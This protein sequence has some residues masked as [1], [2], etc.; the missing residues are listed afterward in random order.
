MSQ[1]RTIM[2]NKLRKSPLMY[3]KLED[4]VTSSYFYAF[5]CEIEKSRN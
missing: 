4:R 2:Y 1:L 3:F 5:F